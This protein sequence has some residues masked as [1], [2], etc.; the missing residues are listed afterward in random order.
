MK[1]SYLALL[2]G[3]VATAIAPLATAAIIDTVGLK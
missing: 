1:I 2:A 3:C